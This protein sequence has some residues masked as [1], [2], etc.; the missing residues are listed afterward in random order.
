MTTKR[1]ST[2]LL[3]IAVA[4]IALVTASFA[5]AP[6]AAAQPL[7]DFALRHPGGMP[8]SLAS[9]IVNYAG[10]QYASNDPEFMRAASGIDTSDYFLRHREGL[11]RPLSSIVVNYAGT[12]NGR[13][14]A[15]IVVQAAAIDTSDYFLRHPELLVK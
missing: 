2:V 1:I 8:A 6:K 9:V 4:A 12:E 5:A 10:S 3:L 11:G 15:Q 7:E 13:R 14:E